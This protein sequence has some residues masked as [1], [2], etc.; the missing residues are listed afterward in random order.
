MDILQHDIFSDLRNQQ[1]P[2]FNSAYIKTETYPLGEVLD[3]IRCGEIRLMKVDGDVKP[4]WK[5][6][7]QE[8]FVTS[9]VNGLPIP[10]MYVNSER[11]GATIIDGFERLAALSAFCQG[12]SNMDIRLNG[13]R[14][15][16]AGGLSASIRK[17]LLSTPVR[18][19]SLTQKTPALLQYHVLQWL[20]AS[21]HYSL[22]KSYRRLVQLKHGQLT[23]RLHRMQ[24]QYNKLIVDLLAQGIAYYFFANSQGGDFGTEQDCV[25]RSYDVSLAVGDAS[26]EILVERL[27]QFMK[28]YA[29]LFPDLAKSRSRRLV[30]ALYLLIVD[31]RFHQEA[32]DLPESISACLADKEFNKLP[33]D[34]FAIFRYLQSHYS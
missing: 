25:C 9:V 34:I 27:Q 12:D 14:V 6:E 16:D 17:K 23:D 28:L 10:L 21:G 8:L 15:S 29:Q 33:A 4:R 24:L 1:V 18:L 30:L 20:N 2:T 26:L 3:R 32:E 7:Q 22:E 5:E 11:D 31:D 13:K 19:C